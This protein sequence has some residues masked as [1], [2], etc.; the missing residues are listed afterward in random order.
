MPYSLPMQFKVPHNLS[1]HDALLRV[2]K[3]LEHVRPQL[4]GKATI[5][6]ERWEGS[7]LHFAFTTERQHV[8]GQLVIKDREFDITAKLPLML[9]LF[10]G[11]IKRAI[12]E[13]M[14]QVM[15]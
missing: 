1:K 5:E 4:L 12:E 2:K 8:S 13:Q 7:T 3:T 6:E 14:K 11:K 9:R 10:E 15:G